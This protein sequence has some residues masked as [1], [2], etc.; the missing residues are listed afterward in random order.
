MQII[1]MRFAESDCLNINTG[2]KGIIRI[3]YE[4]EVKAIEV[5]GDPQFDPV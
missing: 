5:L 3:V 4:N 2:E 1:M